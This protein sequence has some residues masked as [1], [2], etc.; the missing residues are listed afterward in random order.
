MYI[1]P[2]LN[3]FKGFYT[4]IGSR[5]TPLYIMYMLSEIAIILEQQGYVLRSGCAFGA[6]AAVED[7][8]IYPQNTSEI[9]IP[10][11]T[12]PKNAKTNLKSNYI[13]PQDKF[14]NSSNSLYRE[15]M[16]II[17]SHGII[18][19]SWE[20]CKE[21]IMNFHNASIF[22]VLGLDLKTPSKFTIAYTANGEKTPE[23]TGIN[24]GGSTT[25][26]HISYVY[27]VNVFNLGNDN[28]F[29]RFNE[30]I[31]KN[32]SLIDYSKLHS[33]IPRTHLNKK[34]LKYLDFLD[35]IKA[36]KQ[37]RLSNLK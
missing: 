15:A 22:Q 4:G 16:R 20:N 29:I 23:E 11:K 1:P 12:Y 24:T 36:D 31:S 25:A 32:K 17:H 14:G 13:V 6:D 21:Y 10:N 5:T 28:D 34:N 18:G 2:N 27:N 35:K 8:L 30:F 9:Y 37:K 19:R 33:T 26:I 3:F 7:A